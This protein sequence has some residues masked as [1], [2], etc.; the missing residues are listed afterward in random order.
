MET[1]KGKTVSFI[2]LGLMGGAL[3]IGIRKQG[4]DKI[5]AFDIN[6]EVLEDAL[7]KEVIDWGVS[8][9]EGIRQILG[10]SDLVVICLYPQLALDFILEYMEDFKENAVIT[11]ITGVKKLLVDHLRGVLR[12][13]LDL[14]LGHPMAG[15]EKE[16]FGNA[17]DAIFKDRNYILV[18]QPENKPE[19]LSFIKEIIRNLG[20][21]NIVETTAEV[22]DQKIAFTSQLC[23]VIASAL[24]DSEE[25]LHITD[26]EG[27]SFGDL[28]RIAMINAGMWT[29]LFICNKE[30]LVDQ[31]EKFEKSMDTMKKMIQAEDSDGLTEILSN[32]RKKRITMEVDRQ[33]KTS[34]KTQKA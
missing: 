26:Y 14:I 13:D 12:E 10:V 24:V 7:R 20:F 25:D 32:V 19:N 16:G 21:V 29:E 3:A 27:G 33:N 17:D 2:G 9:P 34:A 1:L 4:P 28:T 23:H 5:C 18:P 6:E 30:A 15:S 8:E 31:I 22:H 11:D